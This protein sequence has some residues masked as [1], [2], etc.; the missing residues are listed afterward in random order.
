MLNAAVVF[1]AWGL[2]NQGLELYAA[3]LRK[4]VKARRAELLPQESEELEQW[5]ADVR[6]NGGQPINT[7]PGLWD[8][9]ELIPIL[10]E[11]GGAWKRATK[12]AQVAAQ[13]KRR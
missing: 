10:R 9:R 7:P 5:G 3:H 13:L 4:K 2:V 6:A 8:S 11:H 1:C 12:R